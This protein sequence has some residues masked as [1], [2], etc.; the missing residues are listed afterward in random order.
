[1]IYSG[2]LSGGSRGLLETPPPHSCG[3]KLFQF[4]W[5]SFKKN[6][7]K[8]IEITTHLMDL[9]PLPEILVSPLNYYRRSATIEWDDFSGECSLVVGPGRV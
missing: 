4:Y 3:T 2:G 6:Q 8:Y 1:M 9:N 5:D 7:V